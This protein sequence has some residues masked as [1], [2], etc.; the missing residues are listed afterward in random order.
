MKY[1]LGIV[2]MMSALITKAQ[3]LVYDANAEVRK[4]DAF[5]G[6]SAGGG[7]TVYLSQGTEQAVAVSAEDPKYVSK[8]KTEVKNGV[9]RIYVDAGMWNNWN[10]GNKKIKA[11]VTVTQLN[12]LEFS[13]GSIGKAVDPI[14]VNDLNAECHGGSIITGEFKGNNL[15]LDLSGGSIANLQGAFTSASVDASGGAILN[16]FDA[17]VETCIADAS[18]GSI[19]NV[20][21]NKEL[22]ADAS[23]G[24]I[25][26]YKGSGII[27]RV[28]TSGGSTIRK[29]D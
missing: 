25:V 3:N 19:I 13:G 16:G 10:W 8:I 14:N 7:I 27:K 29:K 23:G 1:I 15:N 22:S 5:K 21:V 12:S 17:T 11:Y 20:S 2:L 24:S 9:L 6:V 26:N 4:V 28:D 18:G